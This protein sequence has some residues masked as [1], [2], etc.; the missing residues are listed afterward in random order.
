VTDLADE[1]VGMLSGEPSGFVP[2]AL[3]LSTREWVED[4]LGG[5]VRLSIPERHDAVEELSEDGMSNRQIAGV[6]GVNDRTA[7]RDQ[8]AANAA[9]DEEPAREG[10]ENMWRTAARIRPGCWTHRDGGGMIRLCVMQHAPFGSASTMPSAPAEAAS[11]R[12]GRCA[13]GGGRV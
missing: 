11:S 1:V 9:P 7:R 10:G 3:G 12:W 4:R 8:A 5:Y 13:R 6:L 2:R